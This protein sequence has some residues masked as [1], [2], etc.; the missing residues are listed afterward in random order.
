[1]PGMFA[2]GM[3]G[4]PAPPSGSHA[5]WRFNISAALSGGYTSVAG[6]EFRATIG[7]ADQCFGGTALADSY[8]GTGYEPANAFD[9]DNETV[10]AS[11][12][13]FPHWCGYHFPAPV[14][15]AEAAIIATPSSYG[16]G[17]RFECPKDFTIEYSDDGS[18]WT[19]A[20]TV[21]GQV[22]WGFNEERAFTVP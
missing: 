19:V 10:W 3:V 14:T 7:G 5:Y 8:Y 22:G 1:M 13:I 9:H 6:L 15:V 12:N 4:E 2:G 18:A 16:D 21:T 11:S 17:S 20:Q